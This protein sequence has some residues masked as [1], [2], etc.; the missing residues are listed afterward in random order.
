MKDE[1][2]SDVTEDARADSQQLTAATKQ[3]I[4]CHGSRRARRIHPATRCPWRG[5]PWRGPCPVHPARHA[6]V[7]LEHLVRECP[8]GQGWS[9]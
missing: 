1:N 6:P 9:W 7:Y 5:C 4:R 2:G 8:Y 3:T